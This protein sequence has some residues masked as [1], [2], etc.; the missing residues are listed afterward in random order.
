[1]EYNVRQSTDDKEDELKA[2][3]QVLSSSEHAAVQTE[4]AT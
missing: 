2:L 1:M 3:V 4:A